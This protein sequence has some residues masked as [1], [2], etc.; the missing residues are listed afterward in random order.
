MVHSVCNVWICIVD[1]EGVIDTWPAPS[2]QSFQSVQLVNFHRLCEIEYCPLDVKELTSR[3]LEL[4]KLEH[5]TCVY[6][7]LVLPNFSF[8]KVAREVPVRMV[9]QVDR[10]LGAL[11]ILHSCLPFH[12]QLVLS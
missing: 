7:K 5:L 12:D 6:L 8:F 11:F 4:I 9:A 3:N 1:F 2:I 10:S